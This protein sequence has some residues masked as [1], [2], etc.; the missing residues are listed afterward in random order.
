MMHT[1]K[2]VLHIGTE[3]R[4][5]LRRYTLT[6]NGHTVYAQTIEIVV[7]FARALAVR[8]VTVATGMC[9]E[10]AA[11]EAALKAFGIKVLEYYDTPER[12]RR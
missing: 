12:T 11:I 8:G 10:D 5:Y 1:T 7:A 3:T 2:P 6:L 4:D 9:G